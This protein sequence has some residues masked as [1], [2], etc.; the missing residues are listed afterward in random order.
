MTFPLSAE[1]VRIVM[2]TVSRPARLPLDEVPVAP[3][4]IAGPQIVLNGSFAVKI[5]DDQVRE[6]RRR[7]K[8]GEKGYNIAKEMGISQP[9]VS[10]IMNRKRKAY[11]V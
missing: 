7:V 1:R 2:G 4:Q 8:A 5:S 10:L 3:E 11:V 6:I 9:M